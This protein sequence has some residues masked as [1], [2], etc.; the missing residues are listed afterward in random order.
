MCGGIFFVLP[1]A[2][3]VAR[4]Q[5][6]ATNLVRVHTCIFFM[7]GVT[8]TFARFEEAFFWHFLQHPFVSDMRKIDLLDGR[9][10]DGFCYISGISLTE[11]I[12]RRLA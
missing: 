7:D 2:G 5:T 10:I 9:S 1:C 3:V 8:G 11:Y 12:R 6:L 4:H